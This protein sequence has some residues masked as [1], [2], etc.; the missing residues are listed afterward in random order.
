MI[1]G[2]AA[3]LYMVFMYNPPFYFFWRCSRSPFLSHRDCI[4]KFAVTDQKPLERKWRGTQQSV[5]GRYV[6][7]NMEIYDGQTLWPPD[8]SRHSFQFDVIRLST[9]IFS[10]YASIC[11]QKSHQLVLF[12]PDFQKNGMRNSVRNEFFLACVYVCV[13]MVSTSKVL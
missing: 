2:S 10:E 5:D 3:A 8:E 13:Y 6:L 1:V 4:A 12:F 7:R 11:I 9:K